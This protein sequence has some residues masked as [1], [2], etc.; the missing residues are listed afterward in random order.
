MVSIHICT[1]KPL[2]S[3]SYSVKR[4]NDRLSLNLAFRNI[5][6]ALKQHFVHFTASIQ[7]REK[8]KKSS[9]FLSYSENTKQM[10]VF[11]GKYRNL[12]TSRVVANQTKLKIQNCIVMK[13]LLFKAA[14]GL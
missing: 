4:G 10:Y 7:G 13:L 2:R 5:L 1:E 8:K 9:S 11:Y 12:W 3:V 14:L 6:I